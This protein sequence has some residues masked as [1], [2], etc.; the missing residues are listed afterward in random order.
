MRTCNSHIYIISN[1]MYYKIGK[2]KCIE[3]RLKSLQTASPSKLKLVDSLEVSHN[4]VSKIENMLHKYLC[5]TR[6]EGEWFELSD[7]TITYLKNVFSDLKKEFKLEKES[8]LKLYTITTKD[9]YNKFSN[10]YKKDRAD[11][12]GPTTLLEYKINMYENVIDKNI[13]DMTMLLL[14]DYYKEYY[15]HG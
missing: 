2:T 14:I 10:K 15:C 5:N 4:K 6:L 1:G 8:F 11:I 13:V 9:I 12:I 7:T 3:Q